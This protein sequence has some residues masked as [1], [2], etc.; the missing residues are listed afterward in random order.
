[1]WTNFSVSQCLPHHNPKCKDSVNILPCRNTIPKL[2]FY[3]PAR[4][5]FYNGAQKGNSYSQGNF[6]SW[7]IFSSSLEWKSI[8]PDP[9]FEKRCRGPGEAGVLGT[10]SSERVHLGSPQGSDSEARQASKWTTKEPDRHPDR[11]CVW[12]LGS[13]QRFVKVELSLQHI[14]ISRN[15]WLAKYIVLEFFQNIAVT[16]N[17]L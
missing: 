10:W 3:V 17:K 4:C 8:K 15:L 5:M 1:M 11:K 9:F 2:S 7:I 14:S 12:Q 16:G 13:C 6:P